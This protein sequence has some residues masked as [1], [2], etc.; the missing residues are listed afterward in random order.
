MLPALPHSPS[1]EYLCQAPLNLY[2]GPDCQTLATQAAQGRQLRFT[3]QYTETAVQVRQAEDGYL[4]WLP[5]AQLSFLEPAPQV[6]QPMLLAR[7]EIEPRL[8]V[9]LDY[10]LKA[11]TRPN[12]YLWG[13]NIGPNYDCSGLVQ[14]AFSSV[15]I[16]LPRDSYQQEA[17]CQ[18]VAMAE[19][20]PGD[21]IF[22]GT[23]RV[24]HVALYL[25]EGQYIHSSGQSMGRNGIGIDLLR[26]DGG[27]IAQA[28]FRKWWSCGR[29]TQ[30]YVPPEDT[31]G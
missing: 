21:L 17:F 14:A 2:D 6:Y 15:G 25:G 20:R 31:L 18:P 23:E 29:V 7:A 4:T 19:L 12:T 3:E 8:A 28:Y 24:D 13:G 11:E 26:E 1:G 22:F 10:A 9:V 30:S 5:L 27:P 16:W